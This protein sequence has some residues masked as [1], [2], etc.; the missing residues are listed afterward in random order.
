MPAHLFLAA[1]DSKAR[2]VCAQALTR[3][4]RST[5]LRHAQEKRRRQKRW[6][7]LPAGRGCWLSTGRAAQQVGHAVS[8]QQGK[9]VE[10]EEVEGNAGTQVWARVQRD[11]G[12]V[13]LRR[14]LDQHLV[15]AV[16]ARGGG[17]A[18]RMG[19]PLMVGG[20]LAQKVRGCVC[21]ARAL[22]AAS[23]SSWPAEAC[24]QAATGALPEGGR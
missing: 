18:A 24:E 10:Q 5:R 23:G 13:Q 16:Q 19:Q 3:Q 17:E 22:L 9:D 15:A 7:A 12:T 2:C 21:T 20:A 6:L 14:A 4:G 8:E 1:P 11:G